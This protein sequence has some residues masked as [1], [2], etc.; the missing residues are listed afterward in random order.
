MV[1]FYLGE[2]RVLLRLTGERLGLLVEIKAIMT[3]GTGCG[4]GV[5]SDV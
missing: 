2:H 5:T 4:S 1:V 3:T